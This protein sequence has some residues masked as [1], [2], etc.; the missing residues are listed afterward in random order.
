MV[1]SRLFPDGFIW[2][3][4]S[5]SYQVEG[6]VAEDGRQPSCWDVYVRSPGATRNRDTGDIACDS[7]HRLDEDLALIAGLGIQS[8]R[9]SIAWPRVVPDG[10]GTVNRA[11][12]AYYERL[13]DSLLE[14]GVEPTVTLFHWDLPE[15]L[16]RRGGWAN[17]DCAEWF[18]DYAVV[19]AEALGD[20]VT[21][22]ITLNEPAVVADRGYR[23]GSHA[24]G[25]R[26][27]ARAAAATH[28]LLLGHGRATQG[29]RSVLG[30]NASVGITLDPLHTVP[31]APEDAEL[32]AEVAAG[33]TDLY[34]RPLLEGAYPTLQR[35]D[36]VPRP[37]IVQPGDLA[38]IAEPIDFLGIN[39]YDP[40]FVTRRHE[41]LGRGEAL[42]PGYPGAV[43]VHPEGFETTSMGWIIDPSSFR[44]LLVTLHS[45]A[46]SLP[47][48]I[49]EN[50]CADHDYADPNGEVHDPQRVAYL[51]GHLEALQQ[52]INEGVDVRGYF[53][54]SLL[55]NFEWTDGYSQRF[56]LVFVDFATQRRIAKDSARFYAEVIANHSLT[57]PDCV[58]DDLR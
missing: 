57:A 47:L 24:P 6:A 14:R 52:A 27:A 2:G 33:K 15:T 31:L 18:A 11:G 10:T 7:Y 51:R 32:A 54:W 13:V 17:R 36:L 53:V 37:P 30:P 56:G 12:M 50:G 38:V 49:T 46:P 9:F 58:P 4:A 34:L 1:A 55:D 16:Q 25:L 48:Y 35:A 43:R 20:R 23:D 22:W 29:L 28:H 45:R 41:V 42:L 21:R 19:V 5:A 44:D 3:A 8:Y 39:Y 26:D 40:V